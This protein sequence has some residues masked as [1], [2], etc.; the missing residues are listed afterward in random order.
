MT[1]PMRTDNVMS[2][3]RTFSRTVPFNEGYVFNNLMRGTISQDI[4]SNQYISTPAGPS[5]DGEISRPADVHQSCRDPSVHLSCRPALRI[6]PHFARPTPP[7][8][9]RFDRSADLLIQR[10]QFGCLRPTSLDP[11]GVACR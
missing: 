10:T 2:F 4:C 9:S 1:R 6:Q 5:D 7:N 3:S 11:S 8:P